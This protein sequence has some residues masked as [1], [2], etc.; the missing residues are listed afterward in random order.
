MFA[1]IALFAFALRYVFLLQARAVPLFN[2]LLM[3]GESYGDWSD[4]IVAG[5][6]LGDRIFYQAPLYPYF[7]AVVKLAVGR[8]LW[9]IRLVQIAIGALSCGVLFLAGR[10][11]FSRKV[12]IAAGVLLACYPTAIFF[13]A[14]IQKA[15]LGLLWTVLL[16]WSLAHA[17]KANARAA[18]WLCTG[19]V[20]GL[21]MLTREET[22]LLVPVLALWILFAR[23]AR[24]R[25]ERV[26]A[27]AT[28]ERARA[29]ALWI[30]GLALV[31]LPVGARNA[32][33]G[34]EF[35]LTTSQ[36]GSNFYIGNN[37]QANGSYSPLRPGRSNTVY[38]R[39]DATDLAQQAV[40]HELTPKEVS[41][42]WFSRAF[43]FIRA[44]PGAWLALMQRKVALLFNAYEM[45]DAE[46]LYFYELYCSLLRVLGTVIN[47]GTLVPLA[48]LGLWWTR[49][50]WRELSILYLVLATFCAGPVIFYVFARYRYPVVPPFT[51]FAGAALVEALALARAKRWSAF[52]WPLVIAAVVAS[53]VN[54]PMFSKDY[55]L[56][57]AHSNAGVA[58]AKLG[59][60][61]AAVEQFKLALA[62]K[63]TSPEIWGNIGVSL[64]RLKRYKEGID[65]YRKALALRGGDGRSELRL[66][67]TLLL[68]G[69]LTEALTWLE[70]AT[71]LRP[72][73][74]EAWSWY[75]DA[76]ARAKRWPQAL[77]ARQRALE[78]A[79]NDVQAA[80][81]LAWLLATAPDAAVRN[82][83]RA[84]A[85]AQRATSDGAR[86]LDVL[87]ACEAELARFDAAAEHARSALALA[88]G[89]DDRELERA[90]EARLALY[91]RAQPFRQAQ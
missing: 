84:L 15:N 46:D 58:L 50:R 86:A 38:E 22:I 12:G 5:D 27:L 4:K 24:P 32:Y 73:S 62:L 59:D 51:L 42:F 67:S 69:Q 1:A 53:F 49:A 91:R 8:D 10:A 18:W 77:D 43:A 9:A 65:A 28:A 39:V 2:A 41:D 30:A 36:A 31:L 57:Q 25:T 75:G 21:L 89:G 90:I 66:G 45:P 54:W 88:R 40:G 20:L 47:Y 44:Q 83:E 78:L 80:L 74:G 52:A 35:V 71:K 76:L 29:L 81:E 55:Q 61:R 16:A 87:A 68:D 19:V 14:L 56:P 82:G 64:V 33:V 17:T 23:R 37:P 7:L 70:R 72:N 60:D 79:P 34:G 85:L 63:P 11:W 48:A 3:D 6:W 13:D 26:R